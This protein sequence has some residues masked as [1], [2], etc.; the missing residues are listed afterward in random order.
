MASA[1]A[2]QNGEAR[3]TNVETMT[4]PEMRMSERAF[5]LVIRA[6]DFI[7]HSSFVIRHFLS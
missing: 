7:R 4:K 2:L 5:R 1:K 3:M 6:S